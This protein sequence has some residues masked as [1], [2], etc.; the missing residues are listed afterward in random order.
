MKI[1]E[2]FSGYGTASFALKQLGIDYECVGYSDIDKYANQC[3]RQNHCP[4]D[5]DRELGDC[6]KIDPNKLD[7]F[8]L[9][10]GG[11]PCQAFSIAGKGLGELDTRG[12]LF[13]E[14]IRIAEVK[15]PRY[16]M[17]ENV[18]GLMSKRHKPT[19]DKIISELYRI[20]YFVKWRVLNTKEHG[21]PQ[22]RERV[23]FVCFKSWT[24]FCNYEWTEKEELKI[25]LKDIL[26]ENVD[27]KY[28]LKK[29]TIKRLLN[30]GEGFKS[31]INPEVG[32]CLFASMHKV[33]RGM[34]MVEQPIFISSLQKHNT[35]RDDGISNCLPSA[36]GMGGG[37]T[38]MI[39]QV[40]PGARNGYRVYNPDGV[41]PTICSNGGGTTRDRAILVKNAT[42]KGYIEAYEGDGISLEHPDSK[43]RRGRVQ[44]Q[45]APTL[46][47]NDAKGVVINPLKEKTSNGWHFEQNVYDKKGIAR[48]VKA[49][50]GSGN[51]P[52]VI[53][54]RSKCTCNNGRACEVC[55]VG[56]GNYLDECD[57][58]SEFGLTIRKLTPTECFRLQGFLNDEVNL[59]GLSN[60]Q[61]YKLA[62]NGQSVNVV[63]K[64]FSS[65]FH[66]KVKA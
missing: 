5:M 8:D 42:K 23:F 53:I 43:T 2:L 31:K 15:K 44:Q 33:A 16:M 32:S 45:I 64:I 4:V 47:C 52:K 22:N 30:N 28:Y 24:D 39:Q 66:G 62:G 41:S 50:G 34:D 63:K 60:T 59:E 10:T 51:I 3:F 11:F 54:D 18:K 57:C 40:N 38:P 56:C 25:F 13:N 35:V 27:E 17:L 20:G 19:F 65:L 9:L 55:C 48:S 14:V 61:Q 46:Q 7:D 36:M 37:H 21:I 12:T 1:L 49:G 58:E 26:E 29:H 6:T